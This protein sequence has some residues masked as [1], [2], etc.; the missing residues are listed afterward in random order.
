MFC[1]QKKNGKTSS[2]V[3]TSLNIKAKNR[4]QAYSW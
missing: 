4:L 1:F 2:S 3:F